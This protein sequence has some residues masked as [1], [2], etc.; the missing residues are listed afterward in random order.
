MFVVD[1]KFCIEFGV[2]GQFIETTLWTEETEV[3]RNQN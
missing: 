3:F 1:R 2:E